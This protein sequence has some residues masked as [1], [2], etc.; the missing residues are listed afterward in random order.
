VLMSNEWMMEAATLVS[1]SSCYHG[2]SCASYRDWQPHSSAG[3][4]NNQLRRSIEAV[5]VRSSTDKSQNDS[6]ISAPSYI[7]C[8]SVSPF[9]F[10]LHGRT[11]GGLRHQLEC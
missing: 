2:S 6:V 9:N 4:Q 5:Q 10:I 3:K 1:M 11:D 8:G 7:Y